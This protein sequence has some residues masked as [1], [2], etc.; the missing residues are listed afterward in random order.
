MQRLDA[1]GAEKIQQY[2]NENIFYDMTHPHS[3]GKQQVEAAIGISGADHYLF[4][5]SFPVFYGWMGQGVDFVENTLD[6]TAE[7]R[8]AVLS[9]NAKRLFNLPID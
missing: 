4:G 8:A 1:T 5:S 9:G 7:E 2:L 3:W 6:I